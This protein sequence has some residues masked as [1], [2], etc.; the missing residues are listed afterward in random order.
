MNK[1]KEGT[2][3]KEEKETKEE[4]IKEEKVKEEPKKELEEKV[5]LKET[6][7]E[8]KTTIFAERLLST[9]KDPILLDIFR[10]MKPNQHYVTFTLEGREVMAL[11]RDGWNLVGSLFGISVSVLEDKREDVYEYPGEYTLLRESYSKNLEKWILGELPED[12][13]KKLKAIED[14][15][16]KL[17]STEVRPTKKY[18]LEI[19]IRVEFIR[20]NESEP[21]FF[22]EESGCDIINPGDYRTEH[23]KLLTRVCNRA[24]RNMTGGLLGSQIV[25]SDEEITPSTSR[26]SQ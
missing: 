24:I 11:T 5:E 7:P 23:F 22:R 16:S 17:H 15:L 19:K 8:I 6:T 1:T 3:V 26:N 13:I 12:S 2:K 10:E 4:N 9:A 21:I 18:S 14:K 25:G 20:L